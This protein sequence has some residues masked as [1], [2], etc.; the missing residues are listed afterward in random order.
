MRKIL[1]LL[2]AIAMTACSGDNNA[3]AQP[4]DL[5]TRVVADD[6]GIPWD[7]RIGPD[8]WIWFTERNGKF[9][10]VNIETG[11]VALIKDIESVFQLN[12]SGLLGFDFHPDFPNTP[13][14]YMVYTYGSIVDMSERLVRFTY[15]NGTLTDETTLV[16]DIDAGHIHDGS[17]VM[18]DPDEM[19]IYMTTGE[20]DEMPY[21]QDLESLNGKT[22]RINPDGSVPADNP[23]G[24]YV[25]T[26]GHRNAQGMVRANGILYQSEHG[27]DTDDEINIIEKGRNYGWPNVN[28]YC[29]KQNEQ[30]FCEDSNVVEPIA[31]WTPTIATCGLDYYG[32]DA[33]PQWKNSLLL[34]TL[35][36]STLYQLQL[37]EDGRDIVE[38]KKFFA[39]TFGRLRDVMV[40]PDGRVF[41]STSNYAGGN[42]IIEI[43]A[44]ETSV[45]DGEDRGS[46]L[47]ISPNPACGG[48][49]V[50]FSAIGAAELYIYNA[51]GEVISQKGMPA[52][53]RES[54]YFEL[55][56]GSYFAVLVG[57]RGFISEPFIVLN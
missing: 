35:K 4:S 9:K 46:L 42:S 10:R 57:R 21:S 39:G 16:D 44:K 56:R 13:Y 34:A 11:E 17:R 54:R 22:L 40:H 50:E 41:I 5:E 12:E 15:S 6:L 23:F 7:M 30:K 48:A 14:I 27:P 26:L 8:G 45:D 19:K 28:G 18:F 52:S 37:S 33:I 53:G 51:L 29:D 38:E 36:G 47:R 43:K 25:W 32:H 1:L 24:N 2:I 49:N 55:P 20:A 31:A 3:S